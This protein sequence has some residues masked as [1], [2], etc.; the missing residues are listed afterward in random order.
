MKIAIGIIGI[1]LGILVLL[2]SC[3][4]GAASHMI[5]NEAGGDAGALGILAGLLL[6]IGGAFAFGL[7]IV[8][9][10]T[11]ALAGLIAFA[12]S[13]AFPDLQ[14]WGVVALAMAAMAFFAWRSSRKAAR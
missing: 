2:Q 8:S 6:F 1:M 13:A 7:P 9:A 14:I 3:T 5:G 12:G 4:I 10:I 11:F